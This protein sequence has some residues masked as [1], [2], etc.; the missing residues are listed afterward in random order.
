M[1]TPVGLAAGAALFLASWTALADS[2]ETTT[3]FVIGGWFVSSLGGI[4]TSIGTGIT[5]RPEYAITTTRGWGIASAVTGTANLAYGAVLVGYAAGPSPC[6][7]SS[8]G[9]GWSLCLDFRGVAAVIGAANV[10]VAAVNGVL[11]G[12][13]LSRRWQPPSNVALIPFALDDTRGRKVPGV[14]VMGR[15]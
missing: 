12:V 14:V 1:K 5:L 4:A 11:A 8:S 3:D 7:S 9:G 15:F 2:T 10:A 13:A 6:T